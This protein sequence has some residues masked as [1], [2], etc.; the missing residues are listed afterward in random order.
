M[1]RLLLSVR[2]IQRSQLRPEGVE[3][4]VGAEE[5]P[6]PAKLLRLRQNPQPNL[7]FDQGAAEAVGVPRT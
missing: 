2:K 1:A 7:L 6:L 4:A 3:E 5:G